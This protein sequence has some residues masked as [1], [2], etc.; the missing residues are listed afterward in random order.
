MLKLWFMTSVFYL[1]YVTMVLY[2]VQIVRNNEVQIVHEIII[3]QLFS[4]NMYMYKKLKP[5]G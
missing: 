4:V 2:D 1:V 3:T 5:L